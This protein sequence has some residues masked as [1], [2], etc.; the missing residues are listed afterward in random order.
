M[1]KNFLIN[2]LFLSFVLFNFC[3]INTI[4]LN[5]AE[6]LTLIQEDVS[7]QLYVHQI[8]FDNS[9]YNVGSDVSG[10]FTL[11]NTSSV[12]L[13]DFYY[14]VSIEGSDDGVLIDES[15][16]SPISY[17]KE[18]SKRE[19][20][21]R[22]GLP[23]SVS[24]DNKLII[25]VY[26]LDGTLVASGY[27]TIYIQ[28]EPQFKNIKPL[29]VVILKNDIAYEKDY[30]LILESGDVLSTTFNLRSNT[31]IS[32]SVGVFQK[33]SPDVFAATKLYLLHGWNLTS[34]RRIKAASEE[35]G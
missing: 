9:T 18:D 33:D 10:V 5:K 35:G 12:S 20:G 8:K 27:Q 6:A 31:S 21:F 28:G 23:K 2:T 7:M 32:A 11:S 19:I 14:T 16:K 29:D 34:G 30:G 15:V 17:I 24:G 26:L 13:Q 25:N 1:K 4:Q 3:L 22:Y